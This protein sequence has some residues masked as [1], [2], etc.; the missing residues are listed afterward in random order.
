M[1]QSFELRQ[2]QKL[3][4]TPQLQ[5]AIRLL[6]MSTSEL[7]L[8]IRHAHETNP[9][10]EM[11]EDGDFRET[12]EEATAMAERES[13]A[14]GSVETPIEEMSD[15]GD[16]P[17]LEFERNQAEF[18]M[19]TWDDPQN[20]YPV[21]QRRQGSSDPAYSDVNYQ[22]NIPEEPLTLKETLANQAILLFSNEQ[23]R[24]IA[25]HLIQ[26]INEAGYID[27][28]L[29]DIQETLNQR[30]PVELADIECVLAEL[31][32][33][34]PTG[35][36]ARNPEECLMLQLKT[37]DPQTP[38]FD[39]ARRI[40]DSHLPK[41]AA[42]EYG[43]LRKTLGIGE[44]E[45]SD[46]VGLIKQ[47]NPHPGYSIGD[48]AVDY[49]VPDILVEKRKGHWYAVLNPGALP[50]L[51]INQDYQ[52]L[53][54]QNAG[55]EFNDLKQQLQHA[56]WLLNNLEKRH[57]TVLSVAREIVSRQQAFFS[58]GPE[59]MRPMTLNDV[60]TSLGV[61]ESTISRATSGKFLSA[62]RGTFELKYFFSAQLG[63]DDGDGISA[64]AIQS[65]IKRIVEQE[66]PGK[67]VSDEKMTKLLAKKGYKVARRTVAKYR[68]QLNI[69]SSSK[70][71]SL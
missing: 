15:T 64:I 32:K 46:A 22:A 6:Q 23:D 27:V 30:D 69:P 7:T 57:Q 17:Q 21:D 31:Q 70:R 26:S 45:L 38:G 49:V 11:G 12:P 59:K 9:L 8:E 4:M 16:V 13:P 48:A 62:P 65:E 40:I 66:D 18:A 43:K 68:E 2:S 28:P 35:V 63:T 67:P 33:L 71:K 37:R 47:L 58:F 34:E 61:H 51:S 36:A 1:K 5:Q 50:R 3:A 56:R 55:D 53:I 52:R 42:K 29:Q 39:S 44:Q 10:L 25:H 19:E 60:A 24:R 14:V 54:N 20:Y 41:L